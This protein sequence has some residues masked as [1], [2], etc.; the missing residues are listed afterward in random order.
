MGWERRGEREDEMVRLFFFLVWAMEG[1]GVL[2]RGEWE[3]T[4]S[5]GTRRKGRRGGQHGVLPD[6]CLV[7]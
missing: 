1:R 6:V 7:S 2:P 3:R 4:K 5:D